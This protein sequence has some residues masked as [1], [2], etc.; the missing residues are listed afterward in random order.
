M[1]LDL[2]LKEEEEG[3]FTVTE[4]RDFQRGIMSIKK[5]DLWATVLT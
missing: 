1:L 3:L 2:D 4:G 5:D